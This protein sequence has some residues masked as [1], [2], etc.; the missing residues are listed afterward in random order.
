MIH[1]MCTMTFNFPNLICKFFFHQRS[2]S[3]GCCAYPMNHVRFTNDLERQGFLP[4]IQ[5]CDPILIYYTKGVVNNIIEIRE[6]L[7]LVSSMKLDVH[8]VQINFTNLD[9]NNIIINEC[10]LDYVNLIKL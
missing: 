10:I 7:W 5:I 6:Y 3:F 4:K 1:N 8:R 2:W 9:I